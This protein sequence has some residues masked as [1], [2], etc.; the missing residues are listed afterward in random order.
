MKRSLKFILSI[1]FCGMVIS[2]FSACEKKET[3]TPSEISVTSN[4]EVELP[5]PFPAMSCGVKLEKAVEKIVC[6][7][8]AA[9]EII[10]E[11][12][13]EKNLVGISNYCDY[14]RDLS[15]KKVGSAENPDIDAIIDLA[16][17]VVFTLSPISERET[18]LLNQA[19]IPVLSPEP[20][21]NLEGYSALYRE[22]AAAFYGKETTDSEKE[23]RK[24]VEIGSKARLELENA[25]KSVTLESYIYVTGK[26]TLAG[27]DTFENAVLSL[28]GL[29]LCTESGYVSPEFATET[30]KYIIV[31][32]SLDESS[33]FENETINGFVEDGA[34]V[35]FVDQ[36]LFER[37]TART[38]E[39]FSEISANTLN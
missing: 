7:S 39:V 27:A 34:E 3:Q 10:C 32:N 8:P 26:L 37:P 21:K 25:A 23:T 19:G 15:V 16:P 30:P 14:P 20:P 6:L 22:I 24:A 2:C 31:D 9:T 35:R 36:R 17:D 18:Y 33:L 38:K 4:G 29:N 1:V 28:S 13:F 5:A 12:G 11:L